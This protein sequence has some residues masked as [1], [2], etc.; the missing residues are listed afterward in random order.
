M[1][2]LTG[3][4]ALVTGAS[5]G[6]GRAIATRLANDGAL[7]AVHYGSNEAAAADTLAEIQRMGGQAFPVRAELG[8]DGDVDTLFTALGKGLDGQGLDILVNN[9]A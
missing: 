7:V 5:R 4:T 2:S 3:K 1:A 9:A 8:V 6:I